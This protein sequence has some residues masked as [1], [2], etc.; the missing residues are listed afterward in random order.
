MTGPQN[1]NPAAANGPRDTNAAKVNPANKDIPS[2]SQG[3]LANMSPAEIIVRIINGDTSIDRLA[4]PVPVQLLLV[5]VALEL[6]R[7]ELFDENGIYIGDSFSGEIRRILPNISK[8]RLS[9]IV[10]YMRDR[11][12]VTA[13]VEKG[14]KQVI[15]FKSSAEADAVIHALNE[16][17]VPEAVAPGATTKPAPTS[18]S[19]EPDKQQ[20]ARKSMVLL[21]EV[22]SSVAELSA[23]PTV[24]FA[25]HQL[26]DQ[27]AG[28]EA[29]ADTIV[30]TVMRAANYN[31]G[32]AAMV[33]ER[34]RQIVGQQ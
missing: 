17:G 8:S 28:A 2:T 20:Q 5:I 31:R 7:S 34:L 33:A 22:P 3:D 21:G 1:D 13:S 29:H 9:T 4:L 24:M 30:D 26:P 14:G 18:G 23:R 11:A 27:L 6:R 10:R 32:I 25:G 19:V 16:L 15:Q 12:K